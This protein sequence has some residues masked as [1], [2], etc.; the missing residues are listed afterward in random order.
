MKVFYN[1]KFPTKYGTYLRSD[2]VLSDFICFLYWSKLISQ[3]TIE[4]MEIKSEYTQNSEYPN[5]NSE[6]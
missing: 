4:N 6:D 1:S 2:L 5:V 3:K